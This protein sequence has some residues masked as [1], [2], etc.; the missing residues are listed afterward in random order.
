MLPFIS[1]TRQAKW[2]SR[3]RST[4][5]VPFDEG[6]ALPVPS[7]DAQNP[8]AADLNELVPLSI[9]RFPDQAYA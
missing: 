3:K 5:L 6:K 9:H 1:R 7:D 4:F 8:E 2:W